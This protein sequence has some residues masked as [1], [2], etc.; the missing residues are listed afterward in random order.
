VHPRT[1]RLQGY[2]FASYPLDYAGARD[3]VSDADAPVSGV[4]S[5]TRLPGAARFG[6]VR[7][8]RSDGPRYA[9]V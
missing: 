3:P 7:T 2:P 1:T 9:S 8:A 6:I 5:V 4:R